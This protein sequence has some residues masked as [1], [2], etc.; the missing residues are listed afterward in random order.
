[1]HS[2]LHC[3]PTKFTLPRVMV[4]QSISSSPQIFLI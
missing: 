2:P 3:L 4:L 1:M